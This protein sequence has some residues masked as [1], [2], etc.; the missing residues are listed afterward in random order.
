MLKVFS[1]R[2]YKLKINITPRFMRGVI[3]Y[4]NFSSKNL[5]KPLRFF[6]VL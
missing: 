6:F 1:K 4:M 2:E 5:S 3:F